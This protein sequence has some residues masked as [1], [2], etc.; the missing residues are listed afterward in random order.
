MI[1]YKP[2]HVN[3]KNSPSKQVK[4]PTYFGHVLYWEPRIEDS[5]TGSRVGTHHAQFDPSLDIAFRLTLQRRA[6]RIL[7]QGG[8]LDSCKSVR[9]G[10]RLGVSIQTWCAYLAAS[11]RHVSMFVSGTETLRS[12]AHV[13][14]CCF[15][16]HKNEGSCLWQAGKLMHQLIPKFCE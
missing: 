8:D 6:L 13:R 3:Q 10:G 7:D 5:S 14:A 1:K 15:P 11:S 2:P 9:V 12:H 16:P 4:R